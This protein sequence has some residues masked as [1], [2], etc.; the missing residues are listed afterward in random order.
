MSVT[1]S[2]TVDHTVQN[3]PISEAVVWA[4]AEAKGVDPLDLDEALY[5]R[6]DPDA[7][8]RLF[9]SDAAGADLRVKFTLA[10]CEVTVSGDGR[11]VVLPPAD[12]SAGTARSATAQD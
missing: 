1:L 9:E 12:A 10:G 6:V 8:E 4:V 2:T 7:L 5:D 11:V 3:E